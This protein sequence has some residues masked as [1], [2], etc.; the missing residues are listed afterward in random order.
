MSKSSTFHAGF[1]RAQDRLAVPRGR[2]QL[3]DSRAAGPGL[4]ARARPTLSPQHPPGT[5]RDGGLWVGPAQQ[6]HGQ[7]GQQ[8]GE[9]EART[10]G[11]G[12]LK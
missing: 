8:C 5:G 6:G 2:E 4:A 12:G 11:Q 3:G 9:L 1:V 7:A 10:D